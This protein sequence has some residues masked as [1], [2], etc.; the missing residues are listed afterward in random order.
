MVHDKLGEFI[1]LHAFK[2][3]KKIIKS[4]TAVDDSYKYDI[5]VTCWDILAKG[6]LSY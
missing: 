4:N 5:N 2:A 6:R 1:N 3:G